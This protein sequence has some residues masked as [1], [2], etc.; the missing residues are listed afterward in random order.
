MKKITFIILIFILF[1]AG[2]AYSE[3]SS[4][5]VGGDIYYPP[6]EY[7]DENGVYKGFNVDITNAISLELGIDMELEPMDWNMAM[8]KLRSGELDALQGVLRSD[9]REEYFDFSEEFLENSQVIFVKSDNQFIKEL[10]DLIGMTVAVQD[11]DIAYERIVSIPGISVLKFKSQDDALKS[12]LNSEVD[13]FVGD[14][15]TG[16]YFVQKNR[17]FDD[18]KI[19]GEVME[20]SPYAFAVSKGDAETL[21]LINSGIKKIKANGTYKKIY[22]KWFGEEIA[23]IGKWKN[24]F[25]IAIA[26]LLAAVVFVLI[27]ANLNRILKREVYKRTE[28]LRIGQLEIAKKDRLKGK[29]IENV[30]AGIVAFDSDGIITN[31]NEFAKDA[32]KLKVAE[33]DSFKDIPLL[34]DMDFSFLKHS[35][36]E[37]PIEEEVV[38]LAGTDVEKT[39]V[40]KLLPISDKDQSDGL[41]FCIFDLTKERNLNRLIAHSDKMQS[42]GVLSAGIAHEIRNPLTSIKMFVDL[43]PLKGSDKKFLEKFSSIVPSELNRLNELTSVLLDYSKQSS[44]KPSELEFKEMVESVLLLIRPYFKKRQIEIVKEYDE[45]KF[46]ADP[47]QFKQILLNILLNSVD[48]IENHGTISISA[49]GTLDKIYI[50]IEDN[51]SG[52]E[53]RILP[54]IFD[55]FYT[56]K[57]HGYGIGLSITKN[58]VSENSGT[59]EVESEKDRGTVVTLSFPKIDRGN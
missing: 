6:Y 19:S 51:G 45:I 8:E 7:L 16:L 9:V 12:L 44:S 41:L 15:L 5:K 10:D 2:K 29:I 26:T 46:W 48:A 28:L 36:L 57:K 52:I 50:R 34:S 30:E 20:T 13:A 58:L 42:L 53:E 37:K 22:R 3:P 25:Y 18:L 14:R 59:I 11:D 38:F 40:Y 55:P 27:M 4:L 32:L 21:E 33:G 39:L 35:V 1:S 56:S 54:K 43:V 49:R 17:Y 47:S 31:I 24:L 23:D